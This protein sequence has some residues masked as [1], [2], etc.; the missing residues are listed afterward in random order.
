MGVQHRMWQGLI[1]HVFVA[2]EDVACQTC[3]YRN[4]N[5]RGMDPRRKWVGWGVGGFGN[6]FY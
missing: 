3:L 6:D 5:F 4:V 2:K 1:S